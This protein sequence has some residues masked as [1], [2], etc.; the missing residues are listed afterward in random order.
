MTRTQLRSLIA[1]SETGS[2]VGA[3]QRLFVSAAAVSAAIGSL[4]REIGVRLLERVGRGVRLTPAGEL[5][6]EYA[7]RIEGLEEEALVRVRSLGDPEGGVLR[8]GAV[9]TV[10]EELLP[11]WLS[12]FRA[13]HPRVSVLLEVANKARLLELLRAHRLDLVVAG[14]PPLGERLRIVATRPHQLL[15]CAGATWAKEWF[16]SATRILP[17][18]AEAVT[19][20][21]REEGS[22]TR[23]STDEVLAA[24]EIQ[25]PS[26]TI[27]SNLAIKRGVE[28]GLGVAVLSSDLVARELERGELVSLPLGPLPSVRRWCLIVSTEET[29]GPVAALVEL[30]RASGDI[31][32]PPALTEAAER[33]DLGRP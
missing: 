21:K 7:R 9:A 23:A 2:V 5:F 1:V 31:E 26:L 11:R 33:D 27:G 24:L 14:R 25:P 6:V 19:W 32:F 12:A 22:G 28:L 17:A 3:A 13:V 4:E 20:L 15:L 30:L 29:P 16:G 10:G 8:I 18:E